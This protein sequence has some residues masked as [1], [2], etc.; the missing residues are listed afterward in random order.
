[1]GV[2]LDIREFR[3]V[4][5]MLPRNLRFCD[6]L[7]EVFVVKGV[8]VAKEVH[9]LYGLDYMLVHFDS[10]LLSPNAVVVYPSGFEEA[11]AVHGG[12]F[13]NF[14]CSSL[15]VASLEN[16][17]GSVMKVINPELLSPSFGL[18]K[19]LCG[20]GL[21][22]SLRSPFGLGETS[23]LLNWKELRHLSVPREQFRCL[24]QS[25]QL[26]VRD[27]LRHEFEVRI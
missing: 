3:S 26:L 10:L 18:G 5:G 16:A 20:E 9:S 21:S 14:L 19:V 13:Q 25:F 2:F 23:D 1:M 7:V 17:F 6:S 12:E 22:H 24:R 11:E 4:D 15:V 8:D 27:S